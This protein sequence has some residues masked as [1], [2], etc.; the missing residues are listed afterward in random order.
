MSHN[1]F[2]GLRFA[3]GSEGSALRSLGHTNAMQA[4]VVLDAD[5]IL[6]VGNFIGLDASGT[7]TLGN[8]LHGVFN[9]GGPNNT[10]GGSDADDGV[11]DGV[12]HARN[13]IS[14]NTQH[15][16]VI[17]GLIGDA[18]AI[19]GALVD[20]LGTVA[21]ESASKLVDSVLQQVSEG[22]GGGGISFAVIVA[23]WAASS[24]MAAVMTALN[25]AYEV[26][27]TRSW[28]KA[29]LV[30]ILL[31]LALMVLIGVSLILLTY[32]AEIAGSIA[33]SWGF[34]PAF[35]TVWQ[36][37]QWP[38]L[39]GLVLLAFN[40]LYLYA[41]NI[42]HWEFH[43]LMPGTVVGVALWLLASFGFNVYVSNFGSYNV[44]YGSLGTVVILLL[45]FYVTGIA[46]LIGAQVNSEIELASD[47]VGGAEDNGHDDWTHEVTGGGVLKAQHPEFEMWSQGIHARSG[48]ACADCHMP[49][50]R[51][52]A[53][54]GFGRC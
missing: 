23:L 5:R 27:E 25:H 41:P 29:R 10:I 43:W 38:V 34:G 49:Y 7:R 19:R 45:W 21:P 48:V 35:T 22:M 30:A 47:K 39:I 54:R 50:Q 28:W 52:G 53:G 46:I 16:I 40:L 37:L 51:E 15:G 3:A 36:I 24:G 4:G 14:G 11:L 32:G 9:A 1:G 42:K 33:A 2:A 6:L 12:V 8:T 18:A 44:T 26:E 31:T 13:V 20:Y 17:G